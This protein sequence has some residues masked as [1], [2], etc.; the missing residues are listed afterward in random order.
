MALFIITVCRLDFS[1]VHPS[2]IKQLYYYF[3]C[4]QQTITYTSFHL[5]ISIFI[6]SVNLFAKLVV[7]LSN[8]LYTLYKGGFGMKRIH[9]FTLT[10]ILLLAFIF[11][12]TVM[13]ANDQQVNVS[14]DVLNV[15]SGP[16][17]SYDVIGQ[18]KRNESVAILA[19][20]DDWYQIDYKGK[21]GWIAS[22]LVQSNANETEASTE[23]V[24]SQVNGLNFRESPSTEAPV[25]SKLSAGDQASFITQ[26]GEWMNISFNGSTG[27]VHEQYVSKISKAESNAQTAEQSSTKASGSFKVLVDALNVRTGPDLSSKRSNI[28]YKG[29]TYPIVERS[30]NWIKIKVNDQEQGWVY[31][32][33]GETAQQASSNTTATN[34]T[35][36]VLSDGTNIRSSATTISDVVKRVNAGEELVVIAE[37]S[38]WY[39]IQLEDGH[40]AYI[41]KWVVS[42]NNDQSNMAEPTEEKREHGT[43]KGL[44]IAVDAGHGGTDKGTIGFRGT[45]EKVVTL[46]TAELLASKL[47]AAGATVVM[48]RESDQYV[49]LNER[50]WKSVQHNADAFISLHYDASLDTSATGFTTFYQHSNQQALANTVNESLNHSVS[51]RNRGVQQGDYYVLRENNSNA[52]LIELGFLSNAMEESNIVSEHYREQATQGIY[53]GIIQYFDSNL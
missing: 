15:R 51:V 14:T 33:H 13:H 28:V 11:S 34:D 19:S 47:Q 37:Q 4:Q 32:F 43:L 10:S 1:Q 5:M 27:W 6:R 53:R 52:I 48:T 21:K 44:T 23:E 9:I 2:L 22:W 50:V 16:G 49:S 18:L 8:F 17:L 40:S 29:E 38:D 7:F 12:G 41:A 42:S 39:E 30:G 26:Q 31:S 25:I 24:I 46:K 3:P 20:S 35:V 45:H 36:T